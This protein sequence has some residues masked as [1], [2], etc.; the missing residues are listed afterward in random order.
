M[1]FIKNKFKFNINQSIG[2]ALLGSKVVAKYRHGKAFEKE[3]VLNPLRACFYLVR[4]LTITTLKRVLAI[5]APKTRLAY[6]VDAMHLTEKVDAVRLASAYDWNASIV[7]E[8]LEEKAQ[9]YYKSSL[10]EDFGIKIEQV[11]SL[12]YERPFLNP[13]FTFKMKEINNVITGR[14]EVTGNR[15]LYFT[16]DGVRCDLLTIL[17]F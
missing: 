4:Y 5:E 10:Y 3:T 12:L 16:R 6:Y 8:K 2:M 17:Y 9:K 15:F 1:I 14:K 11:Y 7:L 13:Y